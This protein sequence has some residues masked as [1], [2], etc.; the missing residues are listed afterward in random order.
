MSPKPT[1]E[2]QPTVTY[3]GRIVPKPVCR[4]IHGEIIPDPSW[5]AYLRDSRYGKFEEKVP[6]GYKSITTKD[7]HLADFETVQNTLLTKEDIYATIQ[8]LYGMVWVLAHTGVAPYIPWEELPNI[9]Y[10]REMIKDTVFFARD[11]AVHGVKVS[12]VIH[13]ASPGRINE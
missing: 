13:Q 12:E 2:F 1:G 10:A 4:D 6:N 11:N 7:G 8:E 5:V 9:E 3:D